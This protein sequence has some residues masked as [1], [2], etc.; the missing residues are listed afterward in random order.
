MLYNSPA[1]RYGACGSAASAPAQG[2]NTGRKAGVGACVDPCGC[3]TDLSGLEPAAATGA[4]E[5]FLL[6]LVF[7][8]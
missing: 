8:A 7:V 1:L 4:M 2:E 5:R 6:A 3:F